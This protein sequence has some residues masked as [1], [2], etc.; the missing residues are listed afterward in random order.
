MY[1]TGGDE[2]VAVVCCENAFKLCN[3]AIL[4]FEMAIDEYNSDDSHRFLLQIAYG[5]E[6]YSSEFSDQYLTL[7]EVQK[8]ADKKM[9]QNKNELKEIA[10]REGLEVIKSEYKNNGIVK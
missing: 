7:R 5:A 9:Y 3:E 10:K 4:K 2:F 8:L 1:R 6:F